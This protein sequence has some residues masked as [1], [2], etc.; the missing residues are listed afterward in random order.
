MSTQDTHLKHSSSA[1]PAKLT[2][3]RTL[4]AGLTA[5]IAAIAANLI[6]CALL[7]AVIDLPADFPPLQAGSIAFFT[8]IGT[9]LG[10]LAFVITNRL[11]KNPFRTYVIV[12]AAALAL[13][14]LPNLGLM[15]NPAGAP[16]PG[17]TPLA[18][19][20]LIVF[21]IVAA[22]VFV[23]VLLRLARG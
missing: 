8:A 14:I 9:A 13:S 21:H 6:V 20:V 4:A 3:R 22:V 10:V 11:S 15:A 1:S 2:N 18:F 12:A 5:M 16:I 19:G 23:G 17:G 7:F